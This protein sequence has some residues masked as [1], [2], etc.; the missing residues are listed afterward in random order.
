M[1]LDTPARIAVIGAGPV[2]L[3]AALYARFLGYEVDVYEQ[4]EVASQIRSMAD[5]K[6]PTAW[7]HWTSPLGLAAVQAQG[8]QQ[9]LPASDGII[10]YGEWLELYLLPL[11]QS[12][13]LQDHIHTHVRVDGARGATTS[14]WESVQ[15]S[16]TS[17]G[18]QEV[19]AAEEEPD[20][21]EYEEIIPLVLEITE[22]TGS[23]LAWADLVIAATGSTIG[24]AFPEPPLP[25]MHRLIDT[26]NMTNIGTPPAL[27]PALHRIRDL[28]AIIADRQSLD[29]YRAMANSP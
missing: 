8:N 26:G 3:E 24:P 5:Q 13:L 27:E 21:E 6:M 11:A 19:E 4:A 29:L 28:F 14:E 22:G 20:S 10:T 18:S 25:H 12:D 15:A 16:S 23:R 2:G 17:D 7:V 9:S 1:A